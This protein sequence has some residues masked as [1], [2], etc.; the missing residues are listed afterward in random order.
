MKVLPRIKTQKVRSP[1]C[2]S[3]RPHATR[4]K[5]KILVIHGTSFVLILSRGVYFRALSAYSLHDCA[6]YANDIAHFGWSCIFVSTRPIATARAY[7][8]WIGCF[9]VPGLSLSITR[10]MPSPPRPYPISHRAKRS[11]HTP[12]AFPWRAMRLSRVSSVQRRYERVWIMR[13]SVVWTC[14]PV[15]LQTQTLLS[16]TDGA[17]TFVR[18]FRYRCQWKVWEKLYGCIWCAARWRI[19]Y[20]KVSGMN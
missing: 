1:P 9:W 14:C 11:S 5:F 15:R 10:R 17:C 12:P 19:F 3:L 16:Q 20:G 7:L 6:P 2:P 18:I 13:V 4:R 8:T